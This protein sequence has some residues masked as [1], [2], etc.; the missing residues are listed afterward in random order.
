MPR[1]YQS[2][3]SDMNEYLAANASLLPSRAEFDAAANP[4]TRPAFFYI[5]NSGHQTLGL[6]NA[7]QLALNNLDKEFG[8]YATC[9]TAAQVPEI[10]R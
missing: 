4:D 2:W 5:H 1:P 6:Y 8:K 10:R 7:K 3:L 9:P